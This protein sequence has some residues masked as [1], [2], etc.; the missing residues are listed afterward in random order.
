MKLWL[1]PFQDNAFILFHT[2]EYVVKMSKAT[3]IS[4]LILIPALLLTTIPISILSEDHNTATTS[5]ILYL[6]K[7]DPENPY[8]HLAKD[9]ANSNS[10]CHSILH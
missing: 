1:K 8:L 2:L 5:A 9:A 3:K 10:K 7:I 4:M 6:E